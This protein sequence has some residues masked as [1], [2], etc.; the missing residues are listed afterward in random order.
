MKNQR[1]LGRTVPGRERAIHLNDTGTRS[2]NGFVRVIF[3][4]LERQ[5]LGLPRL[6]YVCFQIACDS[7]NTDTL[8]ELFGQMIAAGGGSFYYIALLKRMKII[9]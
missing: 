5:P 8:W 3:F 4:F 9:K 7:F 1:H 2:T 6:R